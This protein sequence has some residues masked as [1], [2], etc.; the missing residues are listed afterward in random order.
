MNYELARQVALDLIKYGKTLTR[1]TSIREIT[2]YKRQLQAR[3]DEDTRFE[4]KY[5]DFLR[6][7]AIHN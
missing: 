2:E 7:I 4:V 3:L 1:E 6:C 5:Y